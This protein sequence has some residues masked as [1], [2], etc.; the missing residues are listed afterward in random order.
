M[1]GL[2]LGLN[3]VPE[4]T[5]VMLPNNFYFKKEADF[6][7]VCTILGGWQVAG[8]VVVGYF[9]YNI[10]TAQ[11]ELGLG[12]NFAKELIFGSTFSQFGNL[13]GLRYKG[14]F[15]FEIL[16]MLSSETT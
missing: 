14:N 4:S 1:P 10:S 3:T 6:L 5:H 8:R 7:L 16:V 9:D 11:L 13:A 12:L 2:E 15:A